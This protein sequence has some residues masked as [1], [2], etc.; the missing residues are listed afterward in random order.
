MTERT[1]LSVASGL[2]GA[3][4]LTVIH[5]LGRR[6]HPDAPRMDIVG[7]RAIRQ[8]CQ[9][10]GMRTMG[11]QRLHQL[12]L[13]GDL[14]VNS[15]YYAAVPGRTAAATW[16]R[17][18]GLGLAAGVGALTLPKPLGLGAPPRNDRCANQL[19]TIAWYMAGGLAAAIVAETWERTRAVSAS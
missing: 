6:N 19:M 3:G 9:A 14:L 17:A 15:I 1:V 12:A 11:S 16:S 8:I 13:F 7:V 5:E 2:V 4:T 10:A 18:L